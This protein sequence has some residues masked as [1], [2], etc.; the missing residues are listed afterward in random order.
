[1]AAAPREGPRASR[2]RASVDL[3]PRLISRAACVA[4]SLLHDASVSSRASLRVPLALAPL[5][6]FACSGGVDG[7]VAAADVPPGGSASAD[8][9]SS[10]DA[11]PS[12]MGAPGSDAGAPDALV[13]DAA[14]PDAQAVRCPAGLGARWTCDG[15]ARQRCVDG[16]LQRDACGY[17]CAG[18]A[19]GDDATCTCGPN[20][21]FSH[22]NCLADGDLHA[23]PGGVYV[24]RACGAGG[25]AAGPLGTDDTCNLQSPALGPV[26][27]RLG[28]ECG[29]FSPGTTCGITVRDLVTGETASVRGDS[30]FVSASS[31]K[32]LWVAAALYDVGVAAVAPHADAIFRSSDNYESGAVLDLL[33]SPDRV[34]SFMWNDLGLATS[35]Y[36]AWG[37]GHPRNAANCPPSMGGDNFFT[38]TDVVVFLTAL[39]EG[40]LLGATTSRAELDWM[41]LSPRAGYGGWLGTQLPAAARATM[42]HKA[43]WLPPSAVPGYSNANDVGIVEP[44]GG[45]AYAVALLFAG[46]TSYDAKQL[47]TLEYASCVVYHAVLG[48]VADPFASCTHP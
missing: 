20:A 47:P 43:G 37:F 7:P 10:P 11:G 29:Q 13:R 26:V 19:G 36:C 14:L 16:R 9:G 46:G 6:L 3:A 22:W 41:K 18:A 15:A 2:A 33:A 34:N 17:G 40:S 44:P 39:W 28:G 45:H 48:D 4:G 35:G 30:P 32:A 12:G 42:H 21:S 24:R 23:C 25:C 31:A 38:A 8:A 27:A 5:V 1:M